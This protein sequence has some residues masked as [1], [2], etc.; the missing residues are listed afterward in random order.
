[1]SIYRFI[2]LLIASSL[3]ISPSLAEVENVTYCDALNIEGPDWAGNHTLQLFDPNQ[4]EL[5]GV[6]ITVGVELV[7]NFSC[8]NTGSAPQTV[9]SKTIVELLV[10]TPSFGPVSV[11]TIVLI[12][13]ELAAFDGEEDFSGPSGRTLEG[14]TN[15][16]SVTL[17]YTDPSDFVAALPGEMILLS[18]SA[19][20][21]GGGTVPGNSISA[22][23]GSA[24]SRICVTYTYE[25]RGTG[26]GG[27]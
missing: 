24:E 14:L 15:S 6:T 4:G 1:M 10:E 9:E 27:I 22:M 20:Y 26:E 8:E 12:E 16:S 13:E 11:G 5:L 23:T 21:I 3:T 2:L 7:Q 19:T 25:P 17:E 18:A